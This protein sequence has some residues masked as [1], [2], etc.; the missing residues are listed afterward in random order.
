MADP[1]KA[2][3]NQSASVTL[4]AAGGGSVSLGP[5]S[6]A[7]PATWEVDGAIIQTS[8]PGLAPV[9]KVQLYLDTVS[10]GNSQGLSYDGSYV[11][12]LASNVTVRRGS[13]LICVWTG[14][15]SGDVATMTV[16]GVKY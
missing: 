5:Q 9:P 15:Q 12:A 16:T 3:L 1:V 2:S 10:P 14:G 8:R 11:Q 4:N 6:S 13:L 7:G